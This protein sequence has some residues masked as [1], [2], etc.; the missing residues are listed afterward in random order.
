[1]G[2]DWCPGRPPRSPPGGVGPL[3]VA[4][5]P[6]P[7]L[8]C[9]PAVGGV[10]GRQSRLRA[11]HSLTWGLPLSPLARAEAGCQLVRTRGDL[12][13]QARG[14]FQPTARG[15]LCGVRPAVCHLVSSEPE[16]PR[17]L[18]LRRQ[19]ALSAL[20]LWVSGFWGSLL[21]RDQSLTHQGFRSAQ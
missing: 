6:V 2:A 12:C 11:A 8:V 5:P 7:G 19:T 21:R 20:L 18:T 17:L 3:G 4:P 13:G 9:C 16:R 14:D 1:M 10:R 15:W